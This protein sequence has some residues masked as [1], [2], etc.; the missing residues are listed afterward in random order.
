MWEPHK[1]SIPG[2]Q[3]RGQDTSKS[4]REWTKPEL[5]IHPMSKAEMFIGPTGVDLCSTS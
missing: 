1:V 5:A 3:V 4:R 2:S